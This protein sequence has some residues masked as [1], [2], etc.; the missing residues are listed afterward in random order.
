MEWTSPAASGEVPRPRTGHAAVCLDGERVLVYGGWDYTADGEGFDF[1]DDAAILDT[2]SWSWSV[3]AHPPSLWAPA[4]GAR[5]TA[6]PRHASAK[7][8]ATK[9]PA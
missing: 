8:W 4:A 9:R 3:L 2:R 5:P 1:R 7:C 6:R